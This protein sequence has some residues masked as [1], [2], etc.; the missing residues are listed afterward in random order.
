MV[1]RVC[2][3]LAWMVLTFLLIILHSIGVIPLWP[4]YVFLFWLLILLV[5]VW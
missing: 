1:T 2:I 5:T 3:A 4:L